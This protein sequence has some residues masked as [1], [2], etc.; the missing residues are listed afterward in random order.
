MASGGTTKAVMAALV[1]NAGIA[2]AKFVGFL[3]TGSSAMLA[4]SVHSVADSGNQGLLLLG[5]RAAQRPASEE[6][7]FGSG[8]E[9]YFWAFVVAVVLFALGALF[10]LYEGFSKLREPHAPESL[11]IAIGILCVAIVLEGFSFRTAI[12][13]ANHVRH[14]DS[15]WAFIRHSRN[16]ELPVVLLEDL[17]A[18]VGLVLA[19]IGVVLARYVDPVFDAYATLAIGVLL[20]VIAVILAIE[21]KSL[22]IG[23]AARP[24]DITAIR[25]ALERDGTVERIIHMRTVHIGPEQLFVGAKLEMDSALTFDEVARKINDLESRLR[26]EVPSVEVLYLEPDVYAARSVEGAPAREP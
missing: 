6:R 16:P 17:G 8:R 5:G 18:Q 2:V 20:G 23:E 4:E 25:A 11:G 26:A 13:E 21:M 22:L 12:V 24:R 19:L 14:G 1:A 10:S 7:P 15:W 9:R 3:L